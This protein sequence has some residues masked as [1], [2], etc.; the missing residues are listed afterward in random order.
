MNLLF[1]LITSAGV[2]GL[3]MPASAKGIMTYYSTS[4]GSEAIFYNPSIFSAGPEGYNLS[5]FYTNIYASMRN[6]N[7]GIGRRFN[8]FDIGISVMNY[9]YG[10]IEAKPDYPTED[11]TGF[12]T[13]S[14]FYLGFC[15]AKNV[16]TKGKVGIKVK[17]IYENLYIYT[18]ATLGFDLALAYINEFSGLSAGATNFGGKL[19]IA[20][21]EVNLPAKLSL[22]Y[23]RMIKKFTV[24]CDIHYL[25]N[26]ASFES[27]IAGEMKLNSNL[28]TG[29]SINY[30]DQLYP[31]FYLGIHTRNLTIKYGAS[32]YPYNLGMINTIGIGF[33]F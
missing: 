12:Y 25:I 6:M 10:N 18:D 20:N 2:N 21:E 26:T 1:I 23:Y 24:S 13:G 19:K 7:L 14:D 30:R 8:D 9:N 32:L 15:V 11:S 29:L 17:Y 33:S 5:F 27:S 4:V 16:S 31:G 28:E 3:L 22:G